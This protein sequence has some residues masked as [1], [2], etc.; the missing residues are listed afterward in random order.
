MQQKTKTLI[1]LSGM[2]PAVTTET[3]YVLGQNYLNKGDVFPNRVIVF[4]TLK[5]LEKCNKLYVYIADLC[6]QYK[7]PKDIIDN[8][9]IKIFEDKNGNQLSDIHDEKEQ[10]S[11]ANML[12]KEIRQLTKDPQN[13]VHA[14][15]AGGRK[16]MS[17]YMGYI[18]SMFAR[19]E[20]ELSHVLVDSNYE[21]NGFMFPTKHSC[22]VTKYIDKEPKEFDAKD[23]KV[24]L[25][26]IP[27]IRLRADNKINGYEITDEGSNLDFEGM[28]KAYNDAQRSSQ[29]RLTLNKKTHTISI[30]KNELDLSYFQFL[31]YAY[32]IEQ[33]KNDSL[34]FQRPKNKTGTEEDEYI[35]N[36][37]YAEFGRNLLTQLAE[38]I[39]YKNKDGVMT[40]DYSIFLD[41]QDTFWKDKKAETEEEI[42]KNKIIA[43]KHIL[44][45]NTRKVLM[46]GF[47]EHIF[48]TLKR[49]IK[50][51]I[52]QVC[53][54][55]VIKLTNIE[56][57]SQHTNEGS[58]FY[59][60][61]TN[62]RGVYGLCINP[63]QITIIE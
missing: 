49:N 51:K 55:D 15:I 35:K 23:A 3:L 30:N 59:R 50:N 25:A 24:A 17:F 8:I 34:M 2:S 13:I 21:T 1:T 26:N 38:I 43:K 54:G 27:F 57:V 5:G 32:F 19:E 42:I 16:S 62:N 6:E 61:K 63:N 12:T 52:T 48:D 41:S 56:V 31:F 60:N 47:N 53:V 46:S 18:F 39:N 29:T 37:T 45:M 44:P 7:L 33:T 9:E 10:V 14:S 4:T 11:M 36:E 20:D 58:E 22:M 28:I 40:E